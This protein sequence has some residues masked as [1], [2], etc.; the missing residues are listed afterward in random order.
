MTLYGW[1][2]SYFT[3]KVHCYLRYKGL[4]YRD[5]A[6]SLWT[7]M[8]PIKRRTGAA[9]M[10]VLVT[11]KG[12]W[13]QDS[14]VIIDHLEALHPSPS[15]WPA[16]PVQAFAASVLEAWGD[17]WWVPIAMH[18][19]WSH[20]ENYALFERDTGPSLLPG[21]PRFVQRLAVSRIA[22]LL[23]S[24]L[25]AVGVR[26]EQLPLLDRWTDR[27]LTL[28]DTH[29]AE[30]DF[31]LGQSPSLGDFGL[32]GTMYGHL[33]RDPW[34]ARELIAPR[35]HLRA[36][37]DR[38]AQPASPSPHDTAQ[39]EPPHSDIPRTLTPVFQIIFAQFLPMLQA[40]NE[41]VKA[42]QHQFVPGQPL[43]RRLRDVPIPMEGGVFHRAAMPYTLWMAQRTLDLYRGMSDNAQAAVRQWL[44]PLGGLPWLSL[45][46]PRLKQTG[47]Q[48][49]LE[50]A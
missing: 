22:K 15:I 19:R 27:M 32:V 14:S 3:G 37:I 20:A 36:W 43:P 31:L 12:Q 35:P 8:G 5:Q 18:T 24:Y 46:I 41:Q 49:T 25:P 4:P 28:L 34:P 44:E 21:F 48:V 6:V 38:M 26:P 50:S 39:S 29:F 10:P 45:D 2:L 42:R 23:R 16:D 40:I 47:V 13:L 9:V 1:H 11:E 33:G 30:H 17:E 7:L